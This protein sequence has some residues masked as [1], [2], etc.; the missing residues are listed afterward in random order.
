MASLTVKKVFGRGWQCLEGEHGNRE[1][2]FPSNRLMPHFSGGLFS[3]LALGISLLLFGRTQCQI[4]PSLQV[5]TSFRRLPR[6]ARPQAFVD[7]SLESLIDYYV[8]VYLTN[9]SSS[10]IR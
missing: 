8:R 1:N 10:Q 7:D 4:S 2:R 3:L 5:L 6:L 9:C